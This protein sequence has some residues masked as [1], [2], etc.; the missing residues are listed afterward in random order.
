MIGPLVLEKARGVDQA[1][2]HGKIPVRFDILRMHHF[3]DLLHPAAQEIVQF[4]IRTG[5][6]EEPD[7]FQLPFIHIISMKTGIET[8]GHYG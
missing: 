3:N 5:G 8:G 2:L 4:G 7:P 1:V 6:L